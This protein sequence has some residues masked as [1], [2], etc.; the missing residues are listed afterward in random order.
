MIGGRRVRVRG[1]VRV[2][3][4]YKKGI[5]TKVGH[6]R[7]GTRQTVREGRNVVCVKASGEGF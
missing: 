6:P 7:E 3:F 4:V 1:G 5:Y 2:G